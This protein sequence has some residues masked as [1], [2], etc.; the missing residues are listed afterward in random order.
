[1]IC[2]NRPLICKWILISGHNSGST[3]NILLSKSKVQSAVD[4][5]DEET[6]VTPGP[7]HSLLSQSSR[8]G[9]FILNKIKK[10]S[11]MIVGGG[12]VAGSKSPTS[13]KG[14]KKGA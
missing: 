13:N 6:P 14:G 10:T 3:K 9:S 4:E 7:G 8:T 11:K 12:E 5:G 2:M 1:M